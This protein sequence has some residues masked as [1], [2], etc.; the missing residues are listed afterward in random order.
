MK[1]FVNVRC[2][3]FDA[4]ARRFRASDC[5]L[6]DGA[7]IVALGEEPAGVAAQRIDL[8]G[9]TVVPAF[10]DCHVHL[11]DTGYFS[12]KRDLSRVT[13][14]AEFVAA[15]AALPREDGV[16][17][18]GQYDDARWLDGAS[19]TALPLD[20]F[21]T[22]A[23]AMV[24]RI[25]GHSCLV[26]ATTLAW[27]NLPSDIAGIE[28]DARGNP[29]GKLLLDANW[30][31]QAAF[32]AAMPEHARREAER[33]AVD[34]ALDRGTVH[35]HAQLVGFA[36]DAYAAEVESLRGLPA[37]I[38][39]KICEPDA[40]LAREF[41]LPYIGGDVFLDG[42][43][44]SRTAALSHPYADDGATSGALRFSDDELLA[45][46]AQ[47]EA[48][49]IAAGVHAI[50]DAAIEQCV[51]VWERVLAGKPSPRGCR[52]FIEHFELATQEQI[53][54]CARMGIYLSMQPQFDSLWASD[55]GMYDVRLGTQR[56]R[57]MN[58]LARIARAGG[59][60]CGGDDSPV[61]EL[62]PLLGMQACLDHHEP[63]E[64][65]DAHQALAMYTVDAARLG[66]AEDATGNLAPG[67]A[68]DLV[69]LDRDPLGGARFDEC[70]VLQ[71]WIDGERVRS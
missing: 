31:A 48:L 29:T 27:L 26:N 66:Y 22:Q 4:V 32:L 28:R 18:G 11:T 57:T 10:A 8:G 7:R 45:Y 38:H 30:R 49:G 53:D 20:R 1:L 60:L 59:V 54:A 14:D 35:L 52:H 25:D 71:T 42:S 23:R 6:V 21:H 37:K 50:G 15:V 44:G 51:R 47:A 2:Y 3:S 61:C 56:K 63:S 70:R 12:G 62:N 58:A 64:R 36:R 16:A 41:G 39:P 5:L 24:T 17:F 13:S 40:S 69:V 46:F 19:A 9:A 33:R 67:L 34:T 55:G 68:A 43:L 65:L